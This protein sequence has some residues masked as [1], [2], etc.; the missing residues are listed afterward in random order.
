[1]KN[2]KLTNFFMYCGISR[3]DY[4][5]IRPMLW[6]RNLSAIKI[7]AILS[8]GIGILFFLINVIINSG[9]LFP[10]FFLFGGSMVSLMLLY[11]IKKS[12]STKEIWRFLICYGQMILV[13]IYASILSTQHSN[14]GIPATSVIVFIA[15]LPLS[16]DDHPIRMY[17][18]MILETIGYLTISYLMKSDHAFSLDVMNGATFC[19]VG[20]VIYGIICMRNVREIHQSI[21][22]ERIQRSIISSLAAVVEERDE[23]T[24]DHIQ[25]TE[26]LVERLLD[27]MKNTS[28]YSHLSDDYC[29]YVVLGAPMHDIGKIKIPDAI[30]N[31]PGRLTKEE[32]DIMKK[33]SEYG[34]DIIRETMVDVEEKEYCDIAYNIA[35]HHHE[36]YDGTGYPDGL[37]EEEIPLEARIM[38]LADVYDALVSERVY[39]KAFPK[40]EAVKIIKEGSGTQFDPNLVPLFLECVE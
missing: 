37:K 5:S 38:S 15:L 36:R 11:F 19:V 7:T 30:L 27:C 3:E 20:M 16:I 21:R 23:N 2:N 14:Y 4:N 18:V 17:C 33:H 25:R 9:I 10:Y 40:D 26:T 28:L 12:N 29:S 31:K 22:V 6:A 8:G 32:F 1:M 13:C 39:K 35:R 24:G 34:G